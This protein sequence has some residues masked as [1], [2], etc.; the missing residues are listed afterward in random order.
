MKKQLIATKY[1]KLKRL[2]KKNRDGQNKRIQK[3]K[4]S[5]LNMSADNKNLDENSDL[6]NKQ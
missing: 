1:R 4:V 2:N 6:K 3:V 5:E